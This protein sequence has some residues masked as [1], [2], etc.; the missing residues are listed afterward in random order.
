[1]PIYILSDSTGNLGH[2]LV[3]A[4]LT[5]FPDGLFTVRRTPFLRSDADLRRAFEQIRQAPGV[6]FHGVVSTEMKKRIDEQCRRLGISCRDLT[7][8]FVELLSDASGVRPVQDYNR[9]HRVDQVY[10][11]RIQALEFTLAHDDG[12]GLETLHEAD[13]VLTGVSRTSKTPT[14]I[15]LAQQGFRVGNVALAIE[16][17]PPKELLALPRQKVVGL[18]ID[19]RALAQI[20]TR[21]QTGW[22][23]ADSSYNDR[24][25]V[26]QEVAWSRRLFARQGWAVLDVTN[27]AIE[28][29]AGRIVELMGLRP[30]A[31]E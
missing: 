20:R 24:E 28:E 31:A 8:D 26:E 2:H 9:L 12:L 17:E 27:H 15:F 25:H 30:A 22:R 5:Q 14:G 16:V 7:G 29:T 6:V 21:R 4:I 19:P 23:M 13:V 10:H 11:G 18:L 1:M 3:T